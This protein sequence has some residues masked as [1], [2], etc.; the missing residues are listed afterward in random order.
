MLIL[1]I[2]TRARNYGYVIWPKQFDALMQ[3]E[4]RGA[5]EVNVYFNDSFIGKKTVDWQRR[6][7]S[8]GYSCT[9]T[10]PSTKIAYRITFES[11]KKLTVYTWND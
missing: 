2:T 7:I 3:S 6:R 9:R 1:P 11:P 8:I 5:E 10:L 4:L